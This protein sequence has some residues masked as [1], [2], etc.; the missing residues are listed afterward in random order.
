MK[1]LRKSFG[2][3]K[4]CPEEKGLLV[5]VLTVLRDEQRGCWI[6]RTLRVVGLGAEEVERGFPPLESAR[7]TGG[8]QAGEVALY[9]WCTTS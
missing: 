9:G 4:A 2:G 7:E 1:V 5:P 8:T 6:I 3:L